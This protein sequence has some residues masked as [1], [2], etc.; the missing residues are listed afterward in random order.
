MPISWVRDKSTKQFTLDAPHGAV[1]ANVERHVALMLGQACAVQV[2][3]ATATTWRVQIHADD[4]AAN[5]ASEASAWTLQPSGLSRVHLMR[6]VQSY[7]QG[8][9]RGGDRH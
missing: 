2:Q 9:S 8:T 5:R 3:R 1:Q 6:L 4:P 7:R